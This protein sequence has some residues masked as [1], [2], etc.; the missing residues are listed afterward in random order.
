MSGGQQQRVAVAQAIANN[1]MLLLADESTGNLDSESGKEIM[2]LLKKLNEE[3]M[4][5]I[6]VTHDE[7][8]A[9]Y[10][11]RTVRMVDGK[12]L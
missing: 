12:L 3:G 11:N 7:K 2:C 5:I 9:G 1:P 4:T 8:V 10:A 6:M